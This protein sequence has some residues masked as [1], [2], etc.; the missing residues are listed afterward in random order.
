M[1]RQIT[2]LAV[3][4]TSANLVALE[5][6]LGGEYNVVRANSGPEA[7]AILESGVDIDIILMD[8]QMP[9]LD[10]Y[11]TAER[12]QKMESARNIPIVFVTAVYRDDPWV[13]RGYEAGGI[14]YFSKPFNPDLLRK[15]VGIYA[16]LKQKADLLKERE[17]QIKLSEELLETAKELSSAFGK[18]GVGLVIAD[19]RGNVREINN[20]AL[21]IF[22]VIRS[23]D[24]AENVG[25]VSEQLRSVLQAVKAGERPRRE[26]VQIECGDASR[27][28][29]I[30]SVSP[31]R[32]PDA[33][34]ASVALVLYDITHAKEIEG[35]FERSLTRLTS[36]PV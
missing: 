36:I 29:I 14:D 35:D 8:V 26:V 5:A 9:M 23:A 18:T 32:Q 16:T 27:K 2:V 22:G 24:S 4:D 19:I 28:S 34:V 31:L 7:I 17:R 13:Q 12:I 15:K 30:C 10:G 3:D 1:A 21:R 11:E 25:F 6:V 33:T 20:E